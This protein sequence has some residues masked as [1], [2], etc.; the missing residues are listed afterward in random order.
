MRRNARTHMTDQGFTLLELLVAIALLSLLVVVLF[1]GLRFGA[2]VWDGGAASS[3]RIADVRLTQEFLRRQIEQS[4]QSTIGAVDG[5][6][7]G[8]A[9]ARFEGFPDRVSFVA[10]WPSR[11]ASARLYRHELYLADGDLVVA[12]TPH[13]NQ[14]GTRAGSRRGDLTRVKVLL[15]DGEGSCLRILWGR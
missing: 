9:S 7:G 6:I 13:Q 1:S 3:E 10:P 12:L 14:G 15:R 11:Q 2:R 4:W 8:E 5:D